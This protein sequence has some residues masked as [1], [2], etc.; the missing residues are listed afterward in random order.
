[1]IVVN[2]LMDTIN[3]AIRNA[4]NAITQLLGCLSFF[5]ILFYMLLKDLSRIIDYIPIHLLSSVFFLATRNMLAT[6][7]LLEN[8]LL[9]F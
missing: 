2:T 4:R 6:K 7:E 9:I 3:P 8:K 5:I 1:M